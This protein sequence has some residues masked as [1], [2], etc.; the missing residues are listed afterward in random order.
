MPSAVLTQK[1]IILDTLSLPSH[2]V[3]NNDMQ[4]VLLKCD[5]L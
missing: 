1:S 3:C 4:S 2:A 5:F